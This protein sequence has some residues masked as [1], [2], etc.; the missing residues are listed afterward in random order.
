[1]E[2]QP[3]VLP[4]AAAAI[5]LGREISFVY[6]NWRGETARRRAVPLGWRTG[7]TEWHPEPQLLMRATDLERGAE[8]EFAFADI[9]PG[10]IG[11]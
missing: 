8:R 6:K 5:V 7:S 3:P 1:M 9:V 4:A 11:A 2:H 10:S